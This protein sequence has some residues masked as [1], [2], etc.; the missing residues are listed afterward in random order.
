MRVRY[1]SCC[2]SLLSLLCLLVVA[3][4]PAWC[5]ESTQSDIKFLGV[6]EFWGGIRGTHSLILVTSHYP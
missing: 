2:V 5:D 3:A 6:G 1:L 4:V